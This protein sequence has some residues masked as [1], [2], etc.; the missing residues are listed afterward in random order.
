MEDAP[1]KYAISIDRQLAIVTWDGE[2]QTI[3]DIKIVAE[4]DNEDGK[5][6][7][8]FNDGKV[9]PSGRLWAG[10]MG[11]ESSP[12]IV[13][14]NTGSLYS[15]GK[16]GFKKHCEGIWISNGIAFDGERRKM[17]YIDSLKLA[18]DEFDYDEEEAKICE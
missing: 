17:Y 7:N 16:D 8:R 14:G 13:A 3:Q 4:V 11:P 18:I 9:D 6:E 15:F 1:N 5:R 2:T 10:T 12:G